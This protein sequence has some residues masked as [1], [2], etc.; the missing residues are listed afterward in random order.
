MKGAHADLKNS[1]G[2]WG[3]ASTAAAFLSQFVGALDALGA[4]RHRRRPPTSA[5][6]RRGAGARPATAS[7]SPW[8]WLASFAGTAARR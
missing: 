3:G 6:G 2:R 5:K 4:P 1:G 7:V 8:S